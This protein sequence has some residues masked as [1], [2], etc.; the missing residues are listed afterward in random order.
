[1]PFHNV[2][3]VYG[4]DTLAERYEQTMFRLERIKQDGY[5]VR[6]NCECEFEIPKGWKRRRRTI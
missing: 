6:V 4:D 5:H 2:A 1:M 3:T